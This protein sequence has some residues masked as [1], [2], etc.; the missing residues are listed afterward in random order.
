MPCGTTA[1]SDVTT[2]DGAAQPGAG[3]QGALEGTL[4]RADSGMT[5]C[6]CHAAAT[7][8]PWRP[9]EETMPLKRCF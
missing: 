4:P 5:P 6:L 7:S 8:L 2:W 3:A 9:P 1:A